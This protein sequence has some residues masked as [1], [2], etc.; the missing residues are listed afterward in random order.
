[1]ARILIVDDHEPVRILMRALL[2]RA[3]HEVME[4]S[5]GAIGLRRFFSAGPDLIV[6][7]L[8]MPHT[9]G[10]TALARIRSITDVPVLVC[11]GSRGDEH[12]RALREG[13][14]GYLRKPFD[15]R[16]FTA[17]IDALV[18][19][20]GPDAR[21]ATQGRVVTD[22]WATVDHARH[23]ATVGGRIVVLTPLELRLLSAFVAHGGFALTHDQLLELAWGAQEGTRDQV[24]AAVLSLRAKLAAEVEGGGAALETVRG[25][26]YRWRPL[27]R[28]APSR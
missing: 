12:L 24:K 20:L 17:R 7:D 28:P 6:L 14:D 2:E 9:D 26:G 4:A 8:D 18:R 13:A 11:S 27:R 25:V 15:G 23:E 1:M 19:R 21:D 16:E 5:D 10:F 22:G 3:G